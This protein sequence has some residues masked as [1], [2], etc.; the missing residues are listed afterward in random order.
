MGST[1]LFGL[2]LAAA[3]KPIEERSGMDFY[4]FSVGDYTKKINELCLE[5]GRGNVELTYMFIG[6]NALL[7]IESLEAPPEYKTPYTK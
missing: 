5:S 7:I 6:A 4:K 1:A 2:N 3:A